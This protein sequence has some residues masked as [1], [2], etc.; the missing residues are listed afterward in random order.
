MIEEN[1]ALAGELEREVS[2]LRGRSEAAA[3]E[4]AHA[5]VGEIGR[6]QIILVALALVS[7]VTAFADKV[8]P[9]TACK[10]TA[11]ALPLVSGF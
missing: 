2:A 7:L 1:R 6:G 3:A 10:Q 9:A 11:A 5:S 8:I 4:T